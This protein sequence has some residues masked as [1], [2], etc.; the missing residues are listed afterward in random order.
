MVCSLVLVLVVVVLA[1]ASLVLVLSLV[2]DR[3]LHLVILVESPT[4]VLPAKFV[5]LVLP[6]SLEESS[7]YGPSSP[8][9][10]SNISRLSSSEPSCMSPR[11]STQL[12]AARG[13]G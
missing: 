6:T 5:V 12:H 4:L 2:R 13:W 7:V 8:E 10:S 11:A 1:L 3:I 9:S